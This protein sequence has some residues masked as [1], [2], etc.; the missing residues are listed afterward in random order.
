MAH[1]GNLVKDT[2]V[3]VTTCMIG[4]HTADSYMTNAVNDVE[5]ALARGLVTH[6]MTFE[7]SYFPYITSTSYNSNQS[8][9]MTFE[10]H[11]GIDTHAVGCRRDELQSMAKKPSY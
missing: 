1:N 4:L 2:I 10:K 11:I 3:E 8:F 7:A 5:N 6:R 9:I